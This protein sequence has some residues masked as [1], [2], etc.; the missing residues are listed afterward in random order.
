[1][2]SSKKT[3]RRLSSLRTKFTL[4]FSTEAYDGVA[5][6]LLGLDVNDAG[7]AGINVGNGEV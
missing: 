1:M 3:H 4:I 6:I 5:S 2:D 7:I